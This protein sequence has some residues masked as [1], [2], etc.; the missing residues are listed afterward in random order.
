MHFLTDMLSQYPGAQD[1]LS[2][3]TSQSHENWLLMELKQTKT[4]QKPSQ[5][6]SVG[7]HYLWA[8]SKL[9]SSTPTSHL[10]VFPHFKILR[11]GSWRHGSVVKSTCCSYRGLGSHS[12]N[13]HDGWDAF[14]TPGHQEHTQCTHTQKIPNLSSTIYPF[15]PKTMFFAWD[16]LILRSW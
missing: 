8:N 11:S 13:P 4:K 5:R 9:L 14:W 3:G 16:V 15:T 7:L 1:V 2:H 10:N 6:F 12:R